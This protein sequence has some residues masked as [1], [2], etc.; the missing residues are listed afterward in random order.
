LETLYRFTPGQR[1]GLVRWR[2][3]P[4]GRQRRIFAVLEAQPRPSHRLNDPEHNETQKADGEAEGCCW[5]DDLI[6]AVR[7]H[8]LLEQLGPAGGDG[9]ID[10]MLD[11]LAE[12][13]YHGIDPGELDPRYLRGV[14]HRMMADD[15]P[16][17]PQPQDYFN[18]Q[19]L[20]EP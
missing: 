11:W 16:R 12:L 20:C 2:R 18:G 13:R 7:V 3:E 19:Q 6:P 5:L 4:S 10:L 1:F 17:W 15:P 9:V 14:A 8:L